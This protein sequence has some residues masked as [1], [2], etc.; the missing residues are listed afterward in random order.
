MEGIGSRYTRALPYPE[1]QLPHIPP[2]QEEADLLLPDIIRDVDGNE[3]NQRDVILV[4]NGL[5]PE[6]K[7]FDDDHQETE[8]VTAWVRKIIEGGI[9]P[10]EIGILVRSNNELPRAREV[11]KLAGQT[12]LELS[13]R[14]EN[15]DG[16]ISVGTAPCI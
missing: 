15:R 8:E 14:V 4:F 13:N 11:V 6:V 7:T 16:R 12:L 10:E 5:E 3:E 1:S 2:D 9:N